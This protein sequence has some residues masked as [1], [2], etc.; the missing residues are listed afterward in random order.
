MSEL[1]AK[2]RRGDSERMTSY[3][4][5]GGSEGGSTSESPTQDLALGRA[6]RARDPWIQPPTRVCSLN[7]RLYEKVKLSR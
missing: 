6:A 4:D 3:S 2:L 1:A 5:I 7:F